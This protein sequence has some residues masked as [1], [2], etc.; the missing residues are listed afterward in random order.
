M[1]QKSIKI[2][3]GYLNII[4]NTLKSFKKQKRADITHLNNI[5]GLLEGYMEELE[6]INK[7]NK[8]INDKII[9]LIENKTYLQNEVRRDLKKTD[10]Y[11][12]QIQKHESLKRVP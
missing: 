5:E 6:Y 11:I 10:E 1:S 8:E 7:R 2:E 4:E 3:S 9:K 12:Q